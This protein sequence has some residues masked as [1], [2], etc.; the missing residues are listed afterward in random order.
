[1][2]SSLLVQEPKPPKVA[3]SVGK[4]AGF[5]L[6]L[7]CRLAVSPLAKVVSALVSDKVTVGAMVSTSTGAS[8]VGAAWLRTAWLP[9][10]SL[11]LALLPKFKALAPML[12]P[13]ASLSPG[14]TV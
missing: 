3:L 4:D 8:P 10:L 7:I 9:K 6:N 2:V 11:M 1:M 14:C 12:M 5:S 13:S